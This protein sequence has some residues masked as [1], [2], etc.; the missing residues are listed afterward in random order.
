MDFALQTAIGPDAGRKVPDFV[1]LMLTSHFDLEIL[2]GYF[3][4]YGW[5]G[6]YYFMDPTTGIAVVY[7]TQVVPPTDP[8]VD[9]LWAQL[10]TAL[11]AG[12]KE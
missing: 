6:T 4:G 10:E 9:R 5:A 2:N 12:L 3:E 1:R 7:G 8:E 11:Y